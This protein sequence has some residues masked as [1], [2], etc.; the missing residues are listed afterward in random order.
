MPD[1]IW[2]GNINTSICDQLLNYYDNCTIVPKLS[3]QASPTQ[4][5][6]EGHFRGHGKTSTDLHLHMILS[7]NEG[8][9]KYYFDELS[10]C[11]TEYMEEYT[12]SGGM[13]SVISDGFNI[14]RYQ[15]GEGYTLWHYERTNGE[16]SKR[17]LAWMTYLTDNPD[18]GTEWLHQEKYVAG[19]KGK[20]VIWPAEWTHTHRGRV[21]QKL[22]KTIIT[23]W[24]DLI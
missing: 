24:I 22:E 23:G 16:L 13:E 2:E 12:W 10:R 8:C 4:E 15:P 1:F 21:D 9:L 3:F 17:F 20:T 11:I 19:K 5:M 18:G 14:Q 6:V 7:H